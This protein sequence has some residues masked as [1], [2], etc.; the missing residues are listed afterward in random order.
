VHKFSFSTRHAG[1]SCPFPLPQFSPHF[2][3]YFHYTS[4]L[5]LIIALLRHPTREDSCFRNIYFFLKNTVRWY[6]TWRRGL[7][8]Q[9]KFD[10]PACSDVTNWSQYPSEP[11]EQK[12]MRCHRPD[13]RQCT[14]LC[15][16]VY[17]A[18]GW[19]QARTRAR[20]LPAHL[21]PPHIRSIHRATHSVQ[22]L[23]LDSFLFT[24]ADREGEFIEE[25]L[26]WVTFC[27]HS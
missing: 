18:E 6:W 17:I 25:K 5:N 4:S 13:Q 9:V 8:Q 11:F 16:V 27:F 14:A 20:F 3:V 7:K 21:T 1:T 23:W 26:A 22:R 2:S 15:I 10:H 24:P 19:S 12:A